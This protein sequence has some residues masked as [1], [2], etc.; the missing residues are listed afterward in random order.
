MLCSLLT[1]VCF[2]EFLRCIP[3]SLLC[4]ELH[5]EWMD[6]LE[7]ED[8]DEE[9]QVQDIKRCKKQLDTFAVFRGLSCI[10]LTASP[11]LQNDRPSAQRERPAA[12]LRVG[13]AAHDPRQ[14]PGE[15]DDQLQFVI[16]HLAQHALASWTAIEPRVRE[17]ETGKGE[18]TTALMNF[19]FV[20][21]ELATATFMTL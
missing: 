14:R 5:Q 1:C 8:D 7:D 17:G 18:T 6:V 16:V 2:Q 4:C 11:F 10:I 12:A 19:T 20:Q 15:Q 3:G 21:V 9:E 13:S